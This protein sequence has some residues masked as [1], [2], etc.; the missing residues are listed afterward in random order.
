MLPLLLTLPFII[1]G[2]NIKLFGILLSAYSSGMIIQDFC[3]Y[4]VNPVVKLKEF[5]T[6]F[7]DYYPWLRIKNK[8]IIPIGYISGILIAILSWYFLWK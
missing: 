8:K 4:L 1:Y 2:W 5:W 6:N 3:W 7:S